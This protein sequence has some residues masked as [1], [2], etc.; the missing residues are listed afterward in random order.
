MSSYETRDVSL[1]AVLRALGALALLILLAGLGARV[2]LGAW[3]RLRPDPRRRLPPPEPRLQSDPA[4]DLRRWRA[5]EDAGLRGYSWADRERG[6]IRLPLDR[7]MELVLQRGFP[8]RG[9]RPR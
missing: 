8:A 4:A 2:S 5:E 9:G 6:V 3:S 7:A 1:S